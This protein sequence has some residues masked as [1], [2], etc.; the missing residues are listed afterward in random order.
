MAHYIVTYSSALVHKGKSN[1][2]ERIYEYLFG[3]VVTVI[4]EGSEWMLVHT[5][6]K[7]VDGWIQAEYITPITDKQYNDYCSDVKMRVECSSLFV[8]KVNSYDTLLVPT[9]AVLPFYNF[10]TNTFL[11]ADSEYEILSP[12][13][14]DP[15]I[16]DIRTRVYRAAMCYLNAPFVRNRRSVDGIDDVNLIAN[17]L[18]VVSERVPHSIEELA[19]FGTFLSF[20]EEAQLGDI[21]LFSNSSSG[22]VS[23]CGMYLGNGN[24]LHTSGKVRIDRVDHQGIFNPTL[25]RYSFQLASILS[26]E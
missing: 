22:E 8:K 9:S 14:W 15:N 7:D 26:I 4:E 3:E 16:T 2:T 6:F 24:V 12:M 13:Y 25:K 19:S 11:I 18:S 5:P 17:A 1:K 10:M 23:H 20:I 21:L